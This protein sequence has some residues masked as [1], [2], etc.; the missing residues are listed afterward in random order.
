MKM[1]SMTLYNKDVKDIGKR[2]SAKAEYED[3]VKGAKTIQVKM[4]TLIKLDIQYALAI[5][6]ERLD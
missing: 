4:Y 3:I 1:L 5:L 2:I 6:N